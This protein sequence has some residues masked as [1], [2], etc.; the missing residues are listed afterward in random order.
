MK[1]PTIAMTTGDPKGIGPEIVSKALS[2]PQIKNLASF[3][4]F[5]ALHTNTAL[6]ADEAGLAS[7]NALKAAMVAIQ[8][9]TCD[10]LVTAPICKEHMQM[11]D[12]PHPGHTEF[13]ATAF[14]APEATMMIAASNLRIVLVTIHVSLKKMLQA[15]SAELIMEKIFITQA[16]LKRDFLL[17]NP[18]IAVCGLNPHA[19]ENGLFG[20]EEKEVILPAINRAK[21]QGINVSGPYAA[22]TIFFRARQG[23]FDAVICHYHDQGLIPVKTFSLH[24]GVNIT[25]GLPIVRTSPD[26]GTAF[27]LAGKNIANPQSMK[28]AMQMAV[29]LWKNRQNNS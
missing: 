28:H 2:D 13:L 9:K 17:P 23:E 3:R 8:K 10:A 18:K 19:S 14:Q 16:S 22:D 7:H 4:V 29:T 24:E 21:R 6:S 12:F 1:L 20:D 5:G 15:L 26:H 11:T 25:L 27:D